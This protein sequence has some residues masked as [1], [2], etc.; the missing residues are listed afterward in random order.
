MRRLPADNRPSNCDGR[1][2]RWLCF[3]ARVLLAYHVARCRDQEHRRTPAHDR[4]R[5]CLSQRTPVHHAA[6]NYCYLTDQ[7]K[8]CIGTRIPRES[9]RMTENSPLVERHKGQLTLIDRCTT[10]ARPHFLS[11]SRTQSA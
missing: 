1:V 6:C 7:E 8:A 11:D 2:W 10:R 4:E 3:Y 5:D 9:R